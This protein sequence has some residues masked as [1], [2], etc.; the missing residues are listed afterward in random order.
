MKLLLLSTILQLIP[1]AFLIL[2]SI[3]APTLSSIYLARDGNT[4]YGIFGSCDGTGCTKL[5]LTPNFGETLSSN[6]LS[7]D[8]INKL[9]QGLIVAPIAA[10][11]TF[12]SLVKNLVIVFTRNSS[13]LNKTTALILS[14]LACLSSSFVCVASFLIF[15]PHVTWLSWCLIPAA[16]FN[17]ENSLV[18]ALCFRLAHQPRKVMDTVY[19]DGDRDDSVKLYNYQPSTT[20]TYNNYMEYPEV[21]KSS[22]EKVPTFPMTKIS[23][24]A[25]SVT[26]KDNDA[27]FSEREIK[28]EN[29]AGFGEEDTQTFSSSRSLKIPHIA[30]PY[31]DGLSENH[32]IENDHD[33]KSSEYGESVYDKSE[34]S[35]TSNFTSISQTPINPNYYAGAPPKPDPV[36]YSRNV[37]NYPSNHGNSFT[38]QRPANQFSNQMAGIPMQNRSVYTPKSR[39]YMVMGGPGNNPNMNSDLRQNR[40][41]G[42]PYSGQPLGNTRPVNPYMT[43]NPYMQQNSPQGLSRQ[44]I[45]MPNRNGFVPMKYRNRSNLGNLPPSA[46][47]N[48]N[49]PYSG[50]I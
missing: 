41:N 27:I 18:V 45:T 22:L 8:A 32:P 16:F 11:L 21:E 50:Y 3:S 25:S 6:V 40:N 42:H 28:E 39:P 49:G 14:I 46:L 23:T 17:F 2:A 20:S 38:Q 33:I 34:S 43:K 7:S 10:F 36:N 15:Y 47:D 4:V 13:T 19:D 44:P 12:V 9:S 31:S 35:S 26:T 24:L 5:T 1:L 29:G 37:T 48:D 30:D